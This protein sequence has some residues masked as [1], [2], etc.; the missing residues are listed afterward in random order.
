MNF[1][2]RTDKEKLPLFERIQTFEPGEVVI[3]GD[4]AVMPLMIDHSAFD[5]Y[6]FIVQA[7]KKGKR[8]LH[9]GDFRLHGV[10]SGKMP[11]ILKRY[12][13]NIDYIFHQPYSSPLTYTI[14]HLRNCY[15]VPGLFILFFNIQ[16]S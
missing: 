15:E 6:M 13:R 16:K 12:A 4:I 8:I 2:D 5:A 3:I 9:T 1:I 7:G 10:R 11:F 14:T